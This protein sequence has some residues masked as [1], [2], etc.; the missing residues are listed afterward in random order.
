[1]TKSKS[2]IWTMANVV[3][4][5][6]IC[7]VP[8]FVVALLSDWPAWMPDPVFAQRAK[9]W[10]AMFI[11]ILLSC[12]DALDGYLARSRNEVTAFGQFVDPL[13]DK[14]MVAAALVSLVD[15]HI[16]PAWIAILIL[17]RE[18]IIS[19]LRMLAANK[20]TV[21]AASWYGKAKTVFQIIA[22]ALFII[23]EEFVYVLPIE[24]VKPLHVV[25]W[26]FMCIA[27][28]LTIVS[29]IDYFAKSASLLGFTGEDEYGEEA[30]LDYSRE[31]LVEAAEAVLEHARAKGYSLGCAESLTGGLI[32]ANL[33][34]VP[35]SSDTFKGGIVSYAYEV[36]SSLLSVS[37]DVLAT[38][39]AVNAYTVETMAQNARERLDCTIAVAVSG[40]AGPGGEEPGKPVG[41]VFLACATDDGIVSEEKHF[42]GDREGVR[43][44]TV[45]EAMRLFEDAIAR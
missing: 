12:T 32:A 13:A 29:M 15:L 33:T 26:F 34:A 30:A 31:G 18:F 6:R 25:A 28:L 7:L 27:I 8:V 1:M 38:E 39:G 35:G 4:V 5:I 40:I 11:F 14:I 41:T 45:A 37:E 21:I 24:F 19:G 36:K 2:S 44:Q 23:K 10:V 22:I 42:E 17:S 20:G 3:T 16:L 43:L 9:P